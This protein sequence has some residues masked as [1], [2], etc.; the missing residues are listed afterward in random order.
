MRSSDLW[1]GLLAAVAGFGAVVMGAEGVTLWVAGTVIAIAALFMILMFWSAYRAPRVLLVGRRT[2]G[3][4]YALDGA[5]DQA[6]FAVRCCPGPEVRECPA[7]HGMACPI[8]DHLAA[9]V[10]APEGSYEGDLP[11]CGEALRVPAFDAREAGD[12]DRLV[13]SVEAIVMAPATQ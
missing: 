1:F 2:G 13:Q 3:R 12:P 7:M 10:I 9:A 5:L 8:P 11:P 4:L 6:G